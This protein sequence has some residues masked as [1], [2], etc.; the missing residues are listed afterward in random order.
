[1]IID[2]SVPRKAKKFLKPA[3][4]RKF[5]R[6][7]RVLEENPVPSEEFDVK[8]IKGQDNLFRLRLGQFRVLYVVFWK[9]KVI[10]VKDIQPRKSAYKRF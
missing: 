5:K 1:M 9:D 3:H 4:L 7:V 10:V 6:F 8:K 2:P